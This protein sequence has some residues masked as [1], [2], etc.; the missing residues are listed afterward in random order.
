MSNSWPHPWGSALRAACMGHL[1][2]AEVNKVCSSL[3]VRVISG[4]TLRQR[5]LSRSLHL[6]R[7]ASSRPTVSLPY[8]CGSCCLLAASPALCFVLFGCFIFGYPCRSSGPCAL[9]TVEILVNPSAWWR[10]RL[11]GSLLMIYCFTAPTYKV[12]RTLAQG[13]FG[14]HSHGY[15]RNTN[16]PFTA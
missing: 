14:T 2:W 16:W 15:S 1:S 13:I 9:T 5:L 6:A 11:A 8:Y 3:A 12:S 7:C 10:L 4:L